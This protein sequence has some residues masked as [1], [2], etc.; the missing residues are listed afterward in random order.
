MGPSWVYRVSVLI[1]D[2]LK[3]S[4]RIAELWRISKFQRS[5]TLQLLFRW[6]EGVMKIRHGPSP[7]AKTSTL[8]G[9]PELKSVT[10]RRPKL[11]PAASWPPHKLGIQLL[12]KSG[13]IMTSYPFRPD[14]MT[15]LMISN[16]LIYVYQQNIYPLWVYHL[17]VLIICDLKGRWTVENF[18]IPKVA[19]SSA[20]LQMIWR[21]PMKIR[22]GPSPEAKTPTLNGLPE[23]NRRLWPSLLSETITSGPPSQVKI[24][25]SDRPEEMIIPMIYTHTDNT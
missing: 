4:W 9:L 19:Y 18:E 14:E 11:K 25:T 10:D 16:L 23:L 15:V 21:C 17:S 3:N 1:K 24:T 20:T 7:E 6:F 8:N 22:H 12:F 5:A 2:C 13:P